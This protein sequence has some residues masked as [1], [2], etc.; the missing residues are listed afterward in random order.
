[1]IVGL[2]SNTGNSY[3]ASQWNSRENSRGNSLDELSFPRGAADKFSTSANI[4][5]NETFETL[6]F[7]PDTQTIAKAHRALTE[8]F[9]QLSFSA[10]DFVR[11]VAA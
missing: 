2:T 10:R 8:D 6:L 11:S 9:E 3:Q 7:G 5:S 1:M 4:S